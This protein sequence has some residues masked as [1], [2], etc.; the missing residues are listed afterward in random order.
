MSGPCGCCS[1]SDIPNSTALRKEHEG[2]WVSLEP[3]HLKELRCGCVLG[4]N[5][6]VRLC[7]AVCDIPLYNICDYNITRDRCKELGC[8]FY[9]GVCYEKAVPISTRKP[10]SLPGASCWT[11]L[12]CSLVPSLCL[13]PWWEEQF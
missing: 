9:K 8:C 5:G 11:G 2:Q 1:R 7:F 13:A 12:C 4:A 3:L 6:C 10:I